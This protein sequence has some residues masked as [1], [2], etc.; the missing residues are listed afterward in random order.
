MSDELSR[1]RV[2]TWR[3]LL[4]GGMLRSGVVSAAAS[5]SKRYQLGAKSS[6][7]LR[8]SLGC[9]AVILCY[10][11]VGVGGT[12]I[13]S[14][15]PA[16]VFESQIRFLRRHYR[17][18]PLD[19]VLQEIGGADPGEPAVAITFDDGY[20]GTYSEAF[21]I[22]RKYEI[23]ATVYLTVNCIETGE[24]AWYDRIFLAFQM[25]CKP[26]LDLS[27]A[28]LGNFLLGTR[29]E[30]FGEALRLIRELQRLPNF[31][32]K[33]VCD[34]IDTQIPVDYEATH[35]RMM[36]WDQVREMHRSGVCFGAHT[37]THPVVSQLDAQELRYEL[38]QSKQAI[39][40]RLQTQV[41]H[42]AFPFGDAK[43]CGKAAPGMLRELGYSSGATTIPGV[44]TYGVNP[45]FLYRSGICGIQHVGIF[46]LKLA[47]LFL[48][49]SDQASLLPST[50]LQ[51][52]REQPV[53]ADGERR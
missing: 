4:A 48:Q 32:R 22:L 39:E 10:H 27:P 47:R 29:S 44:N 11:R 6:R 19:Q 34:D 26:N 53:L 40:S 3:A 42:F 52:E 1:E 12:P 33:Q 28:G 45:Y 13:Y 37:M 23:P 15:L 36:N 2:P 20:V 21:P 41:R 17:I 30:R 50:T 43:A 16:A 5:F 46:G 35:N 51:C 7:M 25:A 18:I 9:R 31:Q 49:T 24:I 8:R 38:R 14:Q